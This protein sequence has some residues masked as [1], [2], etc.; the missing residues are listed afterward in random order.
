MKTKT[1]EITTKTANKKSQVKHTSIWCSVN[2]W[3]LAG[4]STI[5]YNIS[6]STS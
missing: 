1:L 5:S 2:I 4:K 6:F 3:Y